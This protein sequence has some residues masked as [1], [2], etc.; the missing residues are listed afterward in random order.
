M[1][2][3]IDHFAAGGDDCL[4]SARHVGRINEAKSKVAYAARPSSLLGISIESKDLPAGGTLSLNRF[5]V[6]IIFD[7]T[8]ESLVEPER[9]FRVTNRQTDVSETMRPD[10]ATSIS[11]IGGVNF[12][13]AN[14]DGRCLRWQSLCH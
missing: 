14:D 11:V 13:R 9:T 2:A 4:R 6:T 10:H 7:H 8:E 5:L 12:E 1:L 3:L